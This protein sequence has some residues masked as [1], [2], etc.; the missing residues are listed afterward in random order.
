MDWGQAL[1]L[2]I[3][4][5]VTEYLP[6]SS[7]GHLILAQRALGIPASE[8]ADAF[9]IVIQAGAIL[10]V[11]GLYA[12]RVR[13]MALGLVGRD[14]VGRGLALALVLA[15][16]PA[17]G[18][19]VPLEG[20]IKKH[21]FDLGPIVAAWAAGGIAILVIFARRSRRGIA[22]DAGLS[23]ESLAWRG[24]L[25]IGAFQLLAVWPGTSRSLVTILG[26]LAV[27]LSLTAAV[28]F[29]FLL[30]VVTLGGATLLDTVKHGQAM[31]DAYGW[32]PLAVGFAAATVSAVIAVRWMVGFIVRRGMAAFGWYRLALAVGVAALLAT[33][34]L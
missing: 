34:V 1:V 22:P 23:L 21:L 26:G 7:T 9:A 31:L 27:G 19:G 29:S 15:L 2:G 12:G 6:V 10:A 5:G 14:P 33:G 8:A 11:L 20:L 28:E 16:A 24:A 13:Q 17:V 3:V 25:I 18:V 32:L 4:E 30:G